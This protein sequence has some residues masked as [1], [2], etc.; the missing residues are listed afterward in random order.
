MVAPERHLYWTRVTPPS[1]PRRA[2]RELYLVL[3]AGFAL[4]FIDPSDRDAAFKQFQYGDGGAAWWS[5]ADYARNVRWVSRFYERTGKALVMWQ[6]PLGNTFMRAMNNTWNHYQDNHVEW[7]IDDPG[8]THLTAY[9]NAGVFAVIFGRGADGATC[10]CDANSDGVTNP[11][12]ITETRRPR[13][14]RTTTGLLSCEGC[15][16]Y[17]GGSIPLRRCATPS[18]DV[19]TERTN[20]RGRN[21]GHAANRVRRRSRS[22]AQ[23]IHDA[24][25][26]T[27]APVPTAPPPPVACVAS[28]GPDPCANKRLVGRF[29]GLHASWYGQSG[30]PTLCVGQRSTATVAFYNSGSIGW[31]SGR[32]GEVAYLGTWGPEPGQD[33]AT[34]LGGDGQLGSPNTGW[35]RYNRIAVQPAQYVGPGQVA[36]FQFTIQAPTTPGTYRLYLRPLIE[37]ASWL[38]DYGVF[39]LVTVRKSDIRADALPSPVEPGSAY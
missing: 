24:G 21:R 13:S 12:P 25:H 27:P 30:Y 34:P 29:A 6:V 37:G 19:A 4:A 23:P 15:R 31:V 32:M 22:N 3:G 20:E 9:V 28:V 33:R 1:I 10:A 2:R 14:M 35:P 26:P 39:W 5:S 38:E 7:L 36:W 11:A 17:A 8:R 16:V 18:A